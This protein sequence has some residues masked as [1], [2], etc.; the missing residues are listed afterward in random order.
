MLDLAEELLLLA[1]EDESGRINQAASTTLPFGLAGAMLMDLTLRERLGM[2][3]DRVVVL[4]ASPT[5]DGVLDSALWEIE[6]DEKSRKA[7]HWVRKLGGWRPKDRVTEQLLERGVLRLQEDYVL[8][9][10]PYNRHLPMDTSAELELRARLR[11]IVINGRTPDARSAALLSLI[12]SCNLVE[13]VFGRADRKRVRERLDEISERELI[14]TAVS[15]TVAAS[16]AATQAAMSASVI[17]ATTSA[18]ASCSTSTSS[19]C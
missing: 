16:Q 18:T 2:E 17:A 11:D 5:G 6:A 9:L 19:S 3:G 1:L 15:D 12:K 10:I 8:W 14:N 7:Q 4:D 13:D